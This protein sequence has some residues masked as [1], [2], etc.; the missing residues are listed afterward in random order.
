MRMCMCLRVC[1]F[2]GVVWVYVHARMHM[3]EAAQ[4]PE[5]IF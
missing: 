2:M 4:E 5:I 3:R 1:L